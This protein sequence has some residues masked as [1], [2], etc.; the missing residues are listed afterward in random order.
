M[1]STII[2]NIRQL[3]NTR[4]Q[5]QL[6]RGKELAELPCIENAYLVIENGIIAE[7]GEMDK[8]GWTD[9]SNDNIIDAADQFVLQ[10]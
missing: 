6:L 8:L 7:Y 9:S 5:N 10:K 4:Q 1:S 3:V 2:T